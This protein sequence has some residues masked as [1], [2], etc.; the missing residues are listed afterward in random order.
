MG[1]RRR[2]T[3]TY[4][5]V[6]LRDTLPGVSHSPGRLPHTPCIFYPPTAQTPLLVR[7]RSPLIF[8]NLVLDERADEPLSFFYI[9]PE[10]SSGGHSPPTHPAFNAPPPAADTHVRRRRREMCS[11]RLWGGRGH[12]PH[13][14]AAARGVRALCA[15]KQIP[16]RRQHT[17]LPVL[18]CKENFKAWQ[19]L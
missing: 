13:A 1:Q 5:R 6:K 14:W 18:A 10:V 4:G 8:S 17:F 11:G 9:C 16:N 12:M 19:L 3:N 7:R 2:S 15:K